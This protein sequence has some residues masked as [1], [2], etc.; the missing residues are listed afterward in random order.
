MCARASLRW[1]DRVSSDVTMM[2]PDRPAL[3]SPLDQRREADGS[4]MDDTTTSTGPEV[5]PRKIS[6]EY[7]LSR[8]VK[9]SSI[10]WRPWVD[11]RTGGRPGGTYSYWS[12]NRCT[13]DRVA[14]ATS[15]RSLSTLDT[16]AGD[17]PAATATVSK[18]GRPSLVTVP[19]LRGVAAYVEPGPAHITVASFGSKVFEDERTLP[20]P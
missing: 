1:S 6:T 8:A 5:T 20:H 14:A 2:A 10:T 12:R 11:R 17:T 9:I 16:V 3:T 7:G 18:V 15:T 13:R 4:S 19:L